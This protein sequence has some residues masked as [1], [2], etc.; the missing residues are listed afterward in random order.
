MFGEC[1]WT[2]ENIDTGVLE[3]MVKRYQIFHYR[4]VHLFLFA[5]NE[6]TDG[7]VDAARKAGNITL[8]PYKDLLKKLT[9]G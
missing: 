9:S 7:C 4:N 1:K 8:V 5:K 2:N 3:T 6:F